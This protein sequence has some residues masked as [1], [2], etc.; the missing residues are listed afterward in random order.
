MPNLDQYFA[1][2]VHPGELH[3]NAAHFITFNQTCEN[4]HG[5]NFHVRISASGENNSDAYVI[6]FV[7]LTR[8]A[9]KICAS[10]T[11]RILLPGES[12]EVTLRT[13]GDQLEVSSYGRYFS[14]PAENC[15]V[16]PVSNTTAEMLAWYIAESL[17]PELVNHACLS[18]IEQLE[19]AVEEADQQWGICKRSFTRVSKA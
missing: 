13:N 15:V 9:A 6:D 16:L 14:L 10:L 5:H 11:N 17:I 1:V 12:R 3:F 18:A 7:L 2:S 8:L 19:V 4:L